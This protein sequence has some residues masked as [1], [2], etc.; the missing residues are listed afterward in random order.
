MYVGMCMFVSV[1]VCVYVSTVSVCLCVNEYVCV[2]VC[3]SLCMCMFVCEWSSYH[4]KF[5]TRKY[6]S[7]T[8]YEKG[9]KHYESGFLQAYVHIN[10]LIFSHWL[11]WLRRTAPS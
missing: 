8:T 10:G 1:C 7:S 6:G 9:H 11:D 4:V 3:V 5:E 2:C